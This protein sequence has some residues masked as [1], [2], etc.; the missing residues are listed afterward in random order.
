MRGAH[1]TQALLS[2]D[3]KLYT[4]TAWMV[5]VLECLKFWP[6]GLD[7]HWP[8]KCT[9]AFCCTVK[10]L[11]LPSNY[12]QNKMLTFNPAFFLHFCIFISIILNLDHLVLHA[13]HA[14]IVQCYDDTGMSDVIVGISCFESV[15]TFL[16]TSLACF[17]LWWIKELESTPRHWQ[18]SH[19]KKHNDQINV[20][21]GIFLHLSKH[22]LLVWVKL[23]WHRI[24]QFYLLYNI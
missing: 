5:L 17:F 18:S 15:L 2:S 9:G 3:P 19:C 8:T 6:D 4:R 7:Q 12:S 13:R 1:S 21:N 11:F 24:K 22:Y 10:H 20:V 16:D 14:G 23:Y